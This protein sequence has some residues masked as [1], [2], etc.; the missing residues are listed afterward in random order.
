MLSDD[1]VTCASD[2]FIKNVFR[3]NFAATARSSLALICYSVSSRLNDP[4]VQILLQ[5]APH[6]NLLASDEISVTVSL[7][8]ILFFEQFILLYHHWISVVDCGDKIIIVLK[9]PLGILSAFVLS[10]YKYSY[11][12]GM[13]LVN[14][15]CSIQTVSNLHPKFC[16]DC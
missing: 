8:V 11:H 7:F 2:S 16:V 14:L 10:C 1:N 4:P 15:H 9:H 13:F 12:R 6:P 5:T 3:E